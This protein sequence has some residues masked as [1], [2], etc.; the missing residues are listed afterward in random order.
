MVV[1]IYTTNNCR[2][3]DYAKRLLTEKEV[4]FH[5]LRI[6]KEPALREEL[7]QRA[8]GVR[9]V[10]QIFIN[11]IHVGGYDKLVLTN[12]NGTLDKIIAKSQLES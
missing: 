7:N 1:D 4:E 12:S 6:D 11:D 3:C 10:P 9:S 2:Y 5:E 8:P